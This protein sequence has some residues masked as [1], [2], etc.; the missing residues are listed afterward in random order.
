MNHKY[1]IG[2]KVKIIG[3]PPQ[4]GLSKF[5]NKVAV[6]TEWADGNSRS[7]HAIY[8]ILIAGQFAF[9]NV[10]E[11]YLESIEKDVDGC[12]CSIPVLMSVGCKCG[13]F[14]KEMQKK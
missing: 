10:S 2:D 14:Q 13:Q 8:E 3:V 4:A 6:I 11:V 5:N 12:I 7:G 9:K 1:K